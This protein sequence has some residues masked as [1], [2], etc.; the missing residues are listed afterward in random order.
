MAGK[1][2]PAYIRLPPAHLQAVIR[3]YLTWPGVADL[4]L[5]FASGGHDRPDLNAGLFVV[6]DHPVHLPQD[7][8]VYQRPL[9]K[10]GKSGELGALAYRDGYAGSVRRH[11]RYLHLALLAAWQPP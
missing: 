9:D 7:C 8:A 6:Q 2:L 10:K 1:Q 4:C 5:F 3:K 11:L